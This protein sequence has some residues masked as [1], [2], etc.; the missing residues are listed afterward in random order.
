MSGVKLLSLDMYDCQKLN[1]ESAK[2]Y[3]RKGKCFIYIGDK[4]Y[5]VDEL[6]KEDQWEDEKLSPTVETNS[7]DFSK[8]F[9]YEGR[10]YFNQTPEGWLFGIMDQSNRS[11]PLI[12]LRLSPRPTVN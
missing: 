11:T 7:L 2:V 10:I 6:P 3:I 5:E 9:T 1:G 4:R 12:V 8:D